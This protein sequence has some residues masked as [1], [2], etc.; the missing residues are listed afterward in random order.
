LASIVG[1]IS[2][3]FGHTCDHLQGGR[4]KNAAAVIMCRSH[5]TAKNHIIFL[6]KFTV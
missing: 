5:S 3:C 6:L 2:T 1:I 4:N